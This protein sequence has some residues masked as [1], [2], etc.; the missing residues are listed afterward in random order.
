MEQPQRIEISGNPSS[1]GGGSMISGRGGATSEKGHPRRS[2]KGPSPE[3]FENSS[4]NMRPVFLA[5][6][7]KIPRLS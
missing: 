2:P 3:K 5:S 7:Y 1:V 4:A 6:G